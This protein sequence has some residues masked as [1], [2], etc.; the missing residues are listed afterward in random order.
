MR[1]TSVRV[2]VSFGDIRAIA[3]QVQLVKS[4]R[5]FAKHFARRSTGSHVCACFLILWLV[6]L[7]VGNSAAGQY[8]F[9][10]LSTESFLEHAC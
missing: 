4:S 8:Q 6:A 1:L 2:A 3:L 5:S 10:A 9:M 7:I